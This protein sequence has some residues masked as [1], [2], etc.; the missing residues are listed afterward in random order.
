MESG[1]EGR[2]GDKGVGEDTPESGGHTHV[3]DPRPPPRGR[4]VGCPPRSPIRQQHPFPVPNLHR[5]LDLAPDVEVFVLQ[6]QHQVHPPRRGH[7]SHPLSHLLKGVDEW[8]KVC[9]I[10]HERIHLKLGGHPR[11]SSTNPFFYSGKG[12]G[13]VGVGEG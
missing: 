12:R 6:Y 8:S 7:K 1:R 10:P 2:D 5:T 11:L 4:S 13:R 3:W 9:G